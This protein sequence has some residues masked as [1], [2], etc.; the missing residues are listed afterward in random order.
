MPAAIAAHVKRQRTEEA[1]EEEE[2]EPEVIDL[3]PN[4]LAVA[5][6]ISRPPLRTLLPTPKA[7]A[8]QTI[9]QARR[10]EENSQPQQRTTLRPVPFVPPP[11]LK[12]RPKTAGKAK[13]KTSTVL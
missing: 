8:I 12:A 7:L 5:L 10:A 6:P 13:A 1:K 11:A 9:Q 2:E 3:E 4:P